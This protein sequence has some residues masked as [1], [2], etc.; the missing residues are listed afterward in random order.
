MD[1]R[2]GRGDF[3]R[4]G[5]RPVGPTV[6]AEVERLARQRAGD[7]WRDL[8]DDAL[9]LAERLRFL[10]WDDR[11]R[12]L[13]G[14]CW[15]RAQRELSL[16]EITGIVNR[17]VRYLRQSP[18]ARRYADCTSGAIAGALMVLGEAGRVASHT[19]ALVHLLSG[20]PAMQEP[21]LAWLAAAG[22]DGLRPAMARLPGFAFLFLV[23]YPN[24]SAESFMARD[25]FFAAMLGL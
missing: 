13:D 4:T 12:I 25:A 16:D 18:A 24:D 1:M 20:E 5:G 10:P 3:Q 7:G 15:S 11:A 6:A 14:Y 22:S 2:R 19:A 21:A 8:C 17:Q 23:L 9:E